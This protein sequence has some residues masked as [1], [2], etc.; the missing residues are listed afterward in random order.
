MMNR[1][2]GFKTDQKL[3]M[4]I[5][6]LLTTMDQRSKLLGKARNEKQE[7]LLSETKTDVKI[8]LVVPT[9]CQNERL[10][11]NLYGYKLFYSRPQCSPGQ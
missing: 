11:M 1:K 2:G 8:K 10:M 5:L 4:Q 6:T 3:R 9:Y 7:F